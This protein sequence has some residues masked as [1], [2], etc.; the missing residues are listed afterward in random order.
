MS[1]PVI[2][3]TEAQAD[4]DEAFDW[5]EK[6]RPGQ[7]STLPRGCRKSSIGSRPLPFFMASCSKMCAKRLSSAFPT[8]SFIALKQLRY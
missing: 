3:R 7:A 6:Q 8:V 4:F 5:Y 2:L 1:L